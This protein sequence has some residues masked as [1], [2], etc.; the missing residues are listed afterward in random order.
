M[1]SFCTRFVNNSQQRSCPIC[2]KQF[3]NCRLAKRRKPFMDF[4][5]TELAGTL[6]LFFVFVLPYVVFFFFMIV[7]TVYAIAHTTNCSKSLQL[8]ILIPGIGY[9]A[10]FL[11]RTAKGVFEIKQHYNFWN[12]HHYLLVML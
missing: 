8:L 2:N 6:V 9:V 1:F 7:F 11:F 5:Q 10:T 12:E 4:L 3:T